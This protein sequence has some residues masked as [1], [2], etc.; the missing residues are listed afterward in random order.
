MP[1]YDNANAPHSITIL[2]ASS[3]RDSGGGVS[4]SHSTR[5]SGIK[6]LLNA[7]SSSEQERLAQMQI[8]CTHVF[9]TT[10]SSARRGDKVTYGSRS[11]HVNGIKTGEEVGGIVSLTYLYLE[12]LL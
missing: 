9:G 6:G 11:F 10:D 3:S 1:L 2:A 5:T 4:L 8:V 7:A 12:E